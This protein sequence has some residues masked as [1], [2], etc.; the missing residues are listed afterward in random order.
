M[1]NQCHDWLQ[2]SHRIQLHGKLIFMFQQGE[3]EMVIKSDYVDVDVDG[4]D[5]YYC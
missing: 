4:E 5:D 1:C 3:G 2:I